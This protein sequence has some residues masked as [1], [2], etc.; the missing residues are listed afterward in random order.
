MAAAS[1]IPIAIYRAIVRL[2]GDQSSA[3]SLREAAKNELRV[4]PPSRCSI[5]LAMSLSS[6]T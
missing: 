3:S 2:V 6:P 4:R 1:L 5:P